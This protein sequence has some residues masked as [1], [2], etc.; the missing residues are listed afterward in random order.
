MNSMVQDFQTLNSKNAKKVTRNAALNAYKSNPNNPYNSGGPSVGSLL[1]QPGGGE[2]GS[3][4]GPGFYGPGS[5]GGGRP[6]PGG[7]PLSPNG[8]GGGMTLEGPNAP[9]GGAGQ[10][11]AGQVGNALSVNH[12]LIRFV[13]TDLEPGASYRYRIAVKI[14]N[15]NFAK[16]DKVADDELATKEFIASEPFECTQTLTVP[17][18]SHLYAFSPKQYEQHV[19]AVNKS[20]ENPEKDPSKRGPDTL[21]KLFELDDVVNGRRAVVQ[22]QRWVAQTTFAGEKEPIGAWV[23]AEIPVAPGEYIGKK[24]LVELP[25]WKAALGRYVFSPT[26]KRLV[27]PWVKDLPQP[28]GRP[29]DF[30]TKDILLDFQGGRVST[31]VDVGGTRVPVQDDSATELLILREDGRIEVRKE[32]DDAVKK[33]RLEREKGWKAWIE[34]V[35]KQSPTSAAGPGA[36]PFGP[37]RGGA[38]GGGGGD[39]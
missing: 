20:V 23:Q 30:R 21:K 17:G 36:G 6:M 7:G 32:L 5:A 2:E 10:P 22:I 34:S 27:S 38:G 33:D 28:I 8:P 9:V 18:E 16:K 25:L 13:D 24:A 31:Q 39:N 15:P 35:K 11:V 19:L 37:G 26:S 14:R 4:G 12:L 3:A 1:G 29:V